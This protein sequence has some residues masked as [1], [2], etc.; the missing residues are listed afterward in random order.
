[1]Y[2]LVDGGWSSW[3]RGSCSKT[4]GGGIRTSTRRCNNPAPSCGGDG[5]SGSSIRRDICNTRCCLG[6]KM[7]KYYFVLSSF[8]MNV[9][10]VQ[11][12]V[13]GVHG[14]M[15]HVVKVVVVE[16]KD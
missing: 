2:C 10:T 5:C 12:M 13:D 9:I 14:D 1:M 3:T 7:Y 11:S 6:K 8:N 16:H 4:C 15:D